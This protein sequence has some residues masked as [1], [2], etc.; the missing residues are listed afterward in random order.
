VRFAAAH[1]VKIAFENWTA[2]N[3]QHLGHW[4]RVFEL[5]PDANVGLNFDPSHL[6]WQ[7][8][9]YLEAVERFGP[10]IF[11]THAKD[12]EVLEHRRREVGVNGGGWWRY[13]IPGYGEIDWG[14]YISRLR[15]VGYDGVLSIEHED[16]TLGREE[17][18]RKGQR[19]LALFV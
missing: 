12:T 10:R 11:H 17:G 4:Q 13:V 3:I 6:F 19:H 5:V 2:T 18:F 8:I 1:K 9:D 16:S 14:V 15:R 7:Q